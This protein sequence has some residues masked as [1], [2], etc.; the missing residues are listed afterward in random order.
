MVWL[1]SCFDP[2]KKQ[3]SLGCFFF[4]FF[5]D[6]KLLSL[7]GEPSS[8]VMPCFLV[9]STDVAVRPASALS[10]FELS[11]FCKLRASVCVA[12]F[13][14][15]SSEC[16]VRSVCARGAR[17]A[18]RVSQSLLR[19]LAETDVHANTVTCYVINTL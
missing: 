17:K 2:A 1:L 4:L 18:S 7:S 12:W 3:R 8:T 10:T 13:D 11:C 5:F 6:S 15:K 14:G 9:V 16:E 19:K